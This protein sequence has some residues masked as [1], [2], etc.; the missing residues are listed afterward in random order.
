MMSGASIG[1]RQAGHANGFVHHGSGNQPS[2]ER[3]IAADLLVPQRRTGT[4]MP[5]SGTVDSFR[6]AMIRDLTRR[7]TEVF[8]QLPAPSTTRVGAASLPPPWDGSIRAVLADHDPAALRLALLH[9]R[10][11]DAAVVS[12]ARLRR[13]EQTLGRWRFKVALWHDMPPAPAVPAI[14]EAA[15]D[16]LAAD[17]DTPSV[18][19]ELHRL[20]IDQHTA[21]GSKFATFAALDEVLG[22]DLE[23]LVG[24]ALR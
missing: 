1:A 14:V 7:L 23:H 2:K 18:L 17:L 8:P 16:A 6:L 20:E 21:S 9:F 5:G 19:R 11:A 10:Y 13:A 3:W 4:S 15:R 24:K 22:L 12:A